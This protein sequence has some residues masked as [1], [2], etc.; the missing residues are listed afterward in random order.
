MKTYHKSLAGAAMLALLFFIPVSHVVAGVPL[1]ILSFSARQSDKSALLEWKTENEGSTDYFEVERS[2]DALVYTSV[3][4]LSACNTGGIHAYKLADAYAEKA[5]R[6][7][8]YR[9]KQVDKDRA[10]TYT[11]IITLSFEM[12]ANAVSLFPNPVSPQSTLKIS[13][14][15]S[16]QVQVRIIDNMGRVIRESIY[17]LKDGTT[18]LTFDAG[19]LLR[20]SYY[21]EV[22]G[23]AFARI[24]P[25]VK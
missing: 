10:V 18:P 19:E 23:M 5:N 13:L 17:Q 9:L 12:T 2:A 4:R 6:I 25:F 1:Q 14:V 20:G 11:P 24:I 8:Y 15:R 21:I 22:R 16:C 3:G 7:L